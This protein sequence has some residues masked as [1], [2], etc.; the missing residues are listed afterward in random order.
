[1]KN[2]F[3]YEFNCVE[4]GEWIPEKQTLE[5]MLVMDLRF[6]WNHRHNLQRRYAQQHLRSDDARWRFKRQQK[7]ARKRLIRDLRAY[8]SNQEFASDVHQSLESW[9]LQNHEKRMNVK[10][11]LTIS[12]AEDPSLFRNAETWERRLQSNEET[13]IPN[14]LKQLPQ[15]CQK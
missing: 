7:E 5:D 14:R 12:W 1:M 15:G 4:N 9:Y 3:F 6:I 8:R 11:L 13:P 2:E 10:R